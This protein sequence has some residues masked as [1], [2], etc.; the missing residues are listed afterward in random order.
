MITI[1][2][3]FWSNYSAEKPEKGAK[4]AIQELKAI[5]ANHGRQL[6]EINFRLQESDRLQLIM[7]DA[8]ASQRGRADRAARGAGATLFWICGQG[9]PHMLSC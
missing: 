9:L 8:L 2:E 6:E 7:Y 3:A 1:A 5:T 4:A